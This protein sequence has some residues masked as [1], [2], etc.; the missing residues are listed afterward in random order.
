VLARP[1]VPLPDVDIFAVQITDVLRAQDCKQ[2]DSCPSFPSSLTV[3][4]PCTL[5]SRRGG[6]EC[7]SAVFMALKKEKAY[8]RDGLTRA[9]C[10][11]VHT[12][13]C[14]LIAPPMR[15]SDRPLTFRQNGATRTLKKK[16]RTYST[17]TVLYCRLKFS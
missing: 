15:C 5:S 8:V 2:D 3:P 10:V 11:P 4:T 14:R 17:C 1:L 16:M 12:G 9:S 6:A 13:P 7:S